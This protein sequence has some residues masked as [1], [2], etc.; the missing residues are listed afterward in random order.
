MPEGF[1]GDTLVIYIEDGPNAP[2]DL[3]EVTVHLDGCEV[4]VRDPGPG[5]W[6]LQGGGG[7]GDGEAFDLA[8]AL[9]DC[10]GW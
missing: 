8:V 9:P 6:T 3:P 4:I 5:P 7:V 10:A 2:L 1:G